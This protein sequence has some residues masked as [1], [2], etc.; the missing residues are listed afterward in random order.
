MAAK[1]GRT[2]TSFGQ[3]F[4]GLSGGGEAEAITPGTVHLSFSEAN[5]I[6]PNFTAVNSLTLALA[7]ANTVTVSLD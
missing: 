3:L 2:I 6:T 4:G 1:R 7:E 5:T